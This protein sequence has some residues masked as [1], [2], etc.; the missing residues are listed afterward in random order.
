MLM[1]TMDIAIKMN[2]W[3]IRKNEQ[4]NKKQ[5]LWR[6]GKH[7]KEGLNFRKVCPKIFGIKFNNIKL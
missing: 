4:E 2:M 1:I 5:A 6:T 7:E 3:R